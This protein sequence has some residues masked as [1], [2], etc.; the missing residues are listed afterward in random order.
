MYIGN[1]PPFLVEVKT[2]CSALKI[3]LEVS[4]KICEDPTIPLLG[5]YPKD[6]PQCQMVLLACLFV[7]RQELT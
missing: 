6:A 3:N 1:T 7:L 5:I 2:C 4:Q